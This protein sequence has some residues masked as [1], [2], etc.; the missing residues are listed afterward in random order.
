MQVCISLQE[1]SDQAILIF[2]TSSLLRFIGVGKEPFYTC[3]LR[4]I[5]VMSELCSI[6]AGDGV[7][8]LFKGLYHVYDGLFYSC[9]FFIRD[10][11][12]KVEEGLSFCEGNQIAIFTF[13]QIGFHVSESGLMSDNLGSL[14]NGHLVLNNDPWLLGQ[15]S[16]SSF[17][18]MPPQQVC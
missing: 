17:T 10:L 14:M 13:N 7:N 6:V 8:L 9:C 2:I 15:L 4:D 16:F 18:V 5:L 3:G 12:N 11:S 1:L